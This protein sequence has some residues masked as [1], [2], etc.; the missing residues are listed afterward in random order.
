MSPI[1]IERKHYPEA[2]FRV[3]TT[4]L[5]GPPICQQTIEPVGRTGTHPKLR[6][7]PRTDCNLEHSKTSQF[8]YL[9]DSDDPMGQLW[10]PTINRQIPK[11]SF[12]GGKLV[13]TLR[14]V[15]SAWGHPLHMLIIRYIGYISTVYIY[16]KHCLYYI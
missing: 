12:G 4:T 3:P 15:A 2:F 11:R 8:Q 13:G 14:D 5:S 1:I 6:P 10:S 16:Q 7:G 9:K